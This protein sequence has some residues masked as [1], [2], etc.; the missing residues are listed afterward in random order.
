VVLSAA[1]QRLMAGL[2]ECQDLGPQTLKGIST[3]QNSAFS[4]IIEH[5][6]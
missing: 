5:L 4:P 2:F 3:P 6:Q 1:T